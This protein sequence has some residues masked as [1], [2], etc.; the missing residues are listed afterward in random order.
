MSSPCSDALGAAPR[1][2]PNDSAGKR[3]TGGDSEVQVPHVTKGGLGGEVLPL[4]L[5]AGWAR[6]LD[7]LLYQ[8]V[9]FP[10][11]HFDLGKGFWCR[12]GGWGALR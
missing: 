10:L 11:C 12:L 7:F 5:T 8:P 4:N 9:S 3:S 2:L 1:P 6:T